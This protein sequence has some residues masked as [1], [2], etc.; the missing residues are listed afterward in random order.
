M[1]SSPYWAPSYM[2]PSWPPCGPVW[3]DDGAHRG[4]NGRPPVQVSDV[5]KAEGGPPTK[6]VEGNNPA[7]QQETRE[8]LKYQGN[9]RPP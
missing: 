7:H 8:I 2:E 3:P 5:E 4:K 9:L 1:S 6:G